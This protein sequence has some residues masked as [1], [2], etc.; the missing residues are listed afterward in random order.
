[1]GSLR[2]VTPL[3]YP[4]PRLISEFVNMKNTSIFLVV[5]SFNISVL[6]W[7]PFNIAA[8]SASGDDQ[9]TASQA[10]SYVGSAGCRSCHEKFYELWSTS[11]H[12]LAMQPYTP[13]FARTH[14]VRQK[15]PI[16]I[17]K[18]R[19]RA[20]VQGAEGFVQE[21]GPQ[22]KNSYAIQHVMGGKNVYYF[23]TPLERGRLQVLPVAFDVR[24]KVWF[25]T[26]ASHI[27]HFIDRRDQP[28]D[29]RE[30]PLTFNTMCYN[31]HVSQLSTNYDVKTD[32]YHTTWVE[33][34]INCET[35]HGPGENTPGYS[36]KH[37]PE[38]HPKTQGQ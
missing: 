27:R 18:V 21:S 38:P 8:A 13:E 28:L 3:R 19:Y 30:W 26:T 29:W 7:S 35:C 5:F 15:K 6:F 16:T 24:K 12:G 17:N 4:I 37:L 20:E 33:P 1:M 23:L 11:F 36:G 22:G 25:D 34:G 10:G 9:Q 32:T 2:Q 14:L 31:C